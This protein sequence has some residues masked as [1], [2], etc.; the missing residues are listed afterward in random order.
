MAENSKGKNLH[1]IMEEM[2]QTPQGPLGPERHRLRR[3][4][5]IREL[6]ARL[7][8]TESEEERNTLIHEYIIEVIKP[9]V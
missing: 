9:K 2:K 4:A 8:T 1:E 7:N 5:L 3:Q 6:M